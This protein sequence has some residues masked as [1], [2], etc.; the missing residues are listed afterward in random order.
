MSDAKNNH[1]PSMMKLVQL[2]A[3][4][5]LMCALF[6]GVSALPCKGA[7]TYQTFPQPFGEYSPGTVFAT[8]GN[9]PILW[10]VGIAHPAF[11]SHS[12]RSNC[13]RG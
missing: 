13:P 8:L 12:S 9:G 11:F 6:G 4:L 2:V 5:L 10:K 7:C 3:S 1:Q